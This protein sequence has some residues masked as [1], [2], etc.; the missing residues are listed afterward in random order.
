MCIRDRSSPYRHALEVESSLFLLLEKVHVLLE[1]SPHR[2]AEV[3]KTFLENQ[4]PLPSSI[5][6]G[7]IGLD[8]RISSNLGE[9]PC[10]G[11]GKPNEFL[12]TPKCLVLIKQVLVK[13]T[14]NQRQPLF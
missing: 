9:S 3:L 4:A 10:S 2:T 5:G 13:I 12:R 14:C 11:Q 8:T 6:D 1:S 7:A